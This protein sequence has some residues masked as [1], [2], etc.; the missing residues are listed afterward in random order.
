MGL[1]RDVVT[2]RQQTVAITTIR[3]AAVATNSTTTEQDRVLGGCR[4]TE[5]TSSQ[6]DGKCW[7]Q[8]LGG[9][10]TWELTLYLCY[11]DHPIY[12]NPY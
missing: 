5:G 7:S 11:Y 10:H 2:L 6:E 12:P 9:P 8:R 4:G 3:A 1:A